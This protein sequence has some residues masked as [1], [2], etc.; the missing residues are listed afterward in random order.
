MWYP[1]LHIIKN[2]ISA[3]PSPVLFVQMHQNCLPTLESILMHQ[4][5]AGR[6]PLSRDVRS[7]LDL[8]FLVSP[9]P[10][11]AAR[12]A[13]EDRDIVCCSNRAALG[14]SWYPPSDNP[15][16]SDP[17]CRA[18]RIASI[19]VSSCPPGRGGSFVYLRSGALLLVGRELRICE[20]ACDTVCVV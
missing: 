1:S 4:Q 17:C 8:P 18:A 5:M 20:S 12:P 10:D 11:N 16:P 13:A 7:I 14:S 3:H 2:H 6:W 9:P 15:S 19:G